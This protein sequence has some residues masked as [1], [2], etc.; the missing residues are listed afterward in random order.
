M[1]NILIIALNIDPSTFAKSY[2]I[3]DIV[4]KEN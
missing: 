1:T 2:K 3:R 4:G